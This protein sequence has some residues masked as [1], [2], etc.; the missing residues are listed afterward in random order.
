MRP[1]AVLIILVLATPL[2]VAPLPVGSAQTCF[3]KAATITDHVSYITGTAG[4]EVMVGD[5]GDNE[6]DAK[7][8]VDYV[9]G[10]GGDDQIVTVDGPGSAFFAKGGKGSELFTDASGGVART[11]LTA[12]MT[13]TRYRAETRRMA[14]SGTTAMT[15]SGATMARTTSSAARARTG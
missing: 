15:R 12:V 8:G 6:I 9:C 2:F 1:L 3:G 10:G 5:D 13:M 14:C 4:N 11:D 7:R